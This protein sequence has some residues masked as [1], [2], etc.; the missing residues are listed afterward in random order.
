MAEANLP[1][2]LNALPAPPVFAD[3]WLSGGDG[4]RHQGSPRICRRDNAPS[5]LELA[6]LVRDTLRVGVRAQH[7]CYDLRSALD[8]HELGARRCEL[9]GRVVVAAVTQDDV[10][11]H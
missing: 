3:L 7:V 1:P 11:Q 2:I 8:R 6:P 10:E 4:D 9:A 5:I